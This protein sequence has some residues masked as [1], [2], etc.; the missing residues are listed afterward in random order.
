MPRIDPDH[1]KVVTYDGEDWNPG[2]I[3]HG[4]ALSDAGG[5]TQFGAYL[6]ILEPGAMSAKRHWHEKEDEF[7]WMIA[8][9]AVLIDDD[10]DHAL[11]PGDAVAF[12]AGVPNGHHVVNRSDAPCRYL[13]VGT[14]AEGEICHYPDHNQT[15]I[16]DGGAWRLVDNATG[17][18]LKQGGGN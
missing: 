11:G 8:G 17:E 12:P 7:L 16:H 13:I 9:H 6:E 4:H 3:S 1:V 2:G 14:R 5:L 10:G 18:I 15:L